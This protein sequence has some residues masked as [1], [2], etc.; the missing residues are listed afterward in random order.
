MAGKE[1]SQQVTQRF[2]YAMKQVIALEREGVDTRAAFAQMIGEHSQ[3]ISKMEH[4]TR[5]PTI[6]AICLMCDAF[7]INPSWLLMGTGDMWLDNWEATL[8]SRLS[9]IEKAVADTPKTRRKSA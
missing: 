4:G 2:L 6:E 3:N 9:A 1:R 5:Y 8:M 7:K